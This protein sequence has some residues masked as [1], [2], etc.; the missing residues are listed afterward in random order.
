LKAVK[1]AAEK[2][3]LPGVKV[4]IGDS[5]EKVIAVYGKPKDE[6]VF[7]MGGEYREKVFYAP[8]PC[9]RNLVYKK[10][11]TSLFNM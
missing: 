9:Q 5:K 3:T 7:I 10:I 4:K 11:L 1:A 2:G 6:P 8:F